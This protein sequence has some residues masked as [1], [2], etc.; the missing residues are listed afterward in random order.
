MFSLSPWDVILILDRPLRL[1][2]YSSMQEYIS[3]IQNATNIR[4][5]DNEHMLGTAEEDINW[6]TVVKFVSLYPCISM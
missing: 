4:K 1:C 5:Y 2:R 6:N 3:I